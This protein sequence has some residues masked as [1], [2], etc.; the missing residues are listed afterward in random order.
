M[1]AT[2]ASTIITLGPVFLS[3]F[4]W[5]GLVELVPAVAA[6]DGA[7]VRDLLPAGAV[8]ATARVVEEATT[9]I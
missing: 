1:H 9:A 3:E 6:I 8:A 7:S 4:F 2:P 5:K